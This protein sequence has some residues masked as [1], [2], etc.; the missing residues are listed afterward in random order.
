[1]PF[2]H[3]NQLSRQYGALM[4]LLL[5]C[6]LASSGCAKRGNQIYNLTVLDMEGKEVSLS[7]LKGT[8]AVVNFWASWC[9][10][11]R[12]EKPQLEKA[13]Q[14]LEP[15]G[16]R[17]V[18]LSDEPLPVI[19]A[20]C[21]QNPDGI[22]YYK[23]KNSIKWLGIFEIPH[24]LLLNSNGKAVQTHTGFNAWSEAQQLEQIRA[25]TQ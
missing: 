23:V 11:C 22:T 16:I 13:R 6:L 9:G 10:P 2:T 12:Q 3:P 25:A 4:F 1:M 24:T 15:E 14:V 19:Q 18:C 8:P 17:F 21:R 20:Y 5:A 7:Y